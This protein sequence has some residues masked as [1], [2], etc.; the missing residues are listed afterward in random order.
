MADI[1]VNS[2]HVIWLK[3]GGEADAQLHLVILAGLRA[4]GHD[5]VPSDATVRIDKVSGDLGHV[6][7][8]WKNTDDR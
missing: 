7:V 5:E 8:S 2:T 3:G 1:K 6:V 4:L